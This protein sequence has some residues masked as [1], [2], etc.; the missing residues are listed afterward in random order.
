MKKLSKEEFI[1]KARKIHKDNFNYL[2]EYYNTKTNIIIQCKSCG[3]IFN[4]RPNAHL[5]QKQGCPKC[6][7]GIVLTTEMFIEQS[8]NIH[9]NFYEYPSIYKNYDTDIEIIC[10]IHGVFFMKPR[11]HLRGC[12]CNKCN[13]KMVSDLKDFINQSII[14]HGQDYDYSESIYKGAKTNIIIKCNNCGEKFLQTPNSHLNGA[15][16]KCNKSKG[17]QKIKKILDKNNIKYIRQKTFEDCKNKNKLPFDFYLPDYNYCIEFD[18]KQHFESIEYF[19]GEKNFQNTQ[20]HDKIKNEYCEKN[21]I[22]LLRITYKDK[23]NE[24]MDFLFNI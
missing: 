4:Q 13:G 11:H 6:N 16:C 10:P 2:S 3:Y 17:E 7:G 18:G 19:G 24:K 12:K 8:N 1:E 20:R 23:I 14:I 5:C 22:F 9:N 21:N 15:G